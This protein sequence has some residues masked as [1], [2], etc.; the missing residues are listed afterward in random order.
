MNRA[1]RFS[2]FLLPLIF[3]SSCS[4]EPSQMP[5]QE[6]KKL[7]DA[8]LAAQASGD[9]AGA[10]TNLCKSIKALGEGPPSAQRAKSTLALASVLL[11]GNKC[12]NALKRSEEAL[13]Y[14]EA[15]YD[16]GKASS[17]LD[18]SGPNFLNSLLLVGESLNCLHR[19]KEA[20][21]VLQRTRTMQ[22]RVIVPLKFNHDLNEALRV[23]LSRTGDRAAARG[24]KDEIRSTESSLDLRGLR[25]VDSLS[26]QESLKEGKSA[27][28]G[29]NLSA[30]E[31]LLKHAM[32]VAK[33]TKADSL[34][35]AESELALGNLYL[36]QKRYSE[37]QPLLEDSLRLARRHLEKKDKGLKEYLKRLAS[38][39]ANAF[40]WKKAA[41][42]DEEAL[43]L[44]FS[45]E[46]RSD[47]HAHRSRDIMDAL[48]DIYKSDSR[49]DKA[50]KL[51]RQKLA[52]E[53]DSYGKSSRKAG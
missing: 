11:A 26:F 6:W 27:Q 9:L 53:E 22:Q 10:E 42:L 49:F 29:G 41:A 2:S 52:L 5:E 19:Y 17:S 45:D 3:L 16:P 28:E 30:A 25:D 51:A 13:A 50:E 23:A 31:K 21:S 34:E 20:L 48:I 18:D 43:T 32:G 35:M 1:R 47:K 37:A 46:M 24:L 14:F 4:S 15:H 7:Y 38:Y 39:Y 40:E 44:I 12:P 8:G 33:K 36:L